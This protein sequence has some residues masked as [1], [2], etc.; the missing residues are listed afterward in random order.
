M[1]V[2]VDKQHLARLQ[3]PFGDDLLLRHG[4]HA[5]L[6]SEDDQIV[7][8]DEIAGGTKP[9]AVERRADLAAVGERDGG[10]TVPRLHQRGVIFVER[11]ALF[12]HQRIAG[13]GFRDQHH[14]RVAE[15]I[16][17]LDQEFERV[18]EAGGVRLALVGDR[19]QLRDVVAEQFGIDARLARG[20]PVDVAAQRVD[21]AVV[22]DHAI[23]MRE[24][25][26]GE[27]VGGEALMDERQRGLVARVQKVPVIGRELMGEHHALVDDGAGRERHGVVLGQPRVAELVDSVR[28][29]LADDEQPTLEVV[30]AGEVR[31][32]A[33]ENLLHHR[34]DRLHALAENLNCRPARRA[35][36]ATV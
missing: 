33:D 13:P 11:A 7:V 21:L 29:H 23:G 36:R 14:H 24:P 19:P 18:V 17:A 34:F 2:Q 4:Q 6:G 9:I 1:L 15:R 26:G 16:A 35:S 10:R 32:A 22:R 30:L 3:A 31:R 25:P 27:G 8:G 28:D 20:H 12:V 5:H